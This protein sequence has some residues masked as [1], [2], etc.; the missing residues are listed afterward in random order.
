MGEPITQQVA[1]PVGARVQ[2]RTMV[3]LVLSQI[4]G[5]VGVGITPS[6]GILLAGQVTH[7]DTLAGPARAA[8]TLGAALLG[9]PLGTLAAARG[10]RVALSL[11]WAIA[12]VGGALLVLAAQADLVVPLF[13]GLLLIG[14]GAAVSLQSR[15][16][17]T[18]LAEPH[19]QGR[20]LSL[21]VWVGTIGSMLGP[22]LGVPG[23]FLGDRIGLNV[24]A[25]AFLIA[26]V[27]LAVASLLIWMLLRPDPLLVRQRSAGLPSTDHPR[28]GAPR[29][30]RLRAVST[31]L[32]VNSIARFAVI[33]ILTAQF[34]MVAVMTATPL[35]LVNQG[36]S[37]SIV[38]ITISLHIV[39]MYALAPAVGFLCD[40]LGARIT[41][42]AG[43][44]ILAVALALATWQSDRTGW[45]IASVILLGLGWAFV[46]VAGST[47]FSSVVSDSTRAA[48]QGGVDTLANLAG[49]VAAFGSGPLLLLGGFGGLAVISLLLLVPLTLLTV[50]TPRAPRD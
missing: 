33:A 17:A 31:E 34:V 22:N 18:D 21:I 49:A 32:R 23:Q 24:Y 13:L 8:G 43:I 41:I 20:S 5:T 40:R 2:R 47:L 30:G 10:R 29:R 4:V 45:V 42:G 1:A 27:C 14:S 12:A 3:V 7:S 44:G 25:A 39:G 26:T 38:G 19:H 50:L 35:H 46:N 15:F 37:I 48:A 11:G 16:A 28:A 9:L 36:G 6:I